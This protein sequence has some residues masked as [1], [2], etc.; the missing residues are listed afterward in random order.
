MT[1]N[2]NI[3]PDPNAVQP[4]MPAYPAPDPNAAPAPY[5]PNQVYVQQSQTNGM[6]IAGLICAFL[7][8][9]L[10]LIF[11]IIGLKKSKQLNGEGKGLSIA[12]II[13]SVIGIIVGIA[14]IIFLFA[15]AS[16]VDPTYYSY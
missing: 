7:F 10:G 11:S 6:A 13:I 8:T 4:S 14:C 15:V 2:N 1:E 12:G 5:A 3:T 9:P 16:S